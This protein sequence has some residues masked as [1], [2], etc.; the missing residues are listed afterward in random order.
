MAQ[1]IEAL[2]EL[3]DENQKT[4]C[5]LRGEFVTTAVFLDCGPEFVSICDAIRELH[6][7]RI[8]LK[9]SLDSVKESKEVVL[10]LVRGEDVPVDGWLVD[11]QHALA[12]RLQEVGKGFDRQEPLK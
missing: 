10:R 3:V 4:I 12:T 9:N 2:T 8:A 5:A 1:T 6:R 11:L 7:E